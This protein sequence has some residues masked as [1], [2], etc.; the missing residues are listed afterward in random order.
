[1]AGNELEIAR[2][3]FSNI[4]SIRLRHLDLVTEVGAP[5]SGGGYTKVSSIEQ[6]LL[7]ST[8]DNSKKAD[9]YINGHGVSVKQTGAS[10]PFN[11]LQRSEILQV[12]KTLGFSEPEK[13]LEK[14]DLAITR[15]HQKEI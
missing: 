10:F 8:Q 7:V 11:R 13:S 5:K 6:L 3:L 1:M 14:I 2:F 4:G 15:F 9:L 12:F